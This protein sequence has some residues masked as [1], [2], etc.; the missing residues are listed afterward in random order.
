[1][2]GL[3]DE[4]GWRREGDKGV[5][6]R[7][8]SSSLDVADASEIDGKPRKLITCISVRGTKSTR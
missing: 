3:V 1:M 6:G 8:W 4:K 5:D 7:G 2:H